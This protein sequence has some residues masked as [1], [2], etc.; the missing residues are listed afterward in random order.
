VNERLLRQGIL[1]RKGI[2][3]TGGCCDGGER[4]GISD[5]ARWALLDGARGDGDVLGGARGV[6]DWGWRVF[7]LLRVLEFRLGILLVHVLGL[8]VL[9]MLLMVLLLLLLLLLRLL[10]L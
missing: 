6:G 8:E 4:D 1:R 3:G 7:D 2:L 5:D 9:L 10:L